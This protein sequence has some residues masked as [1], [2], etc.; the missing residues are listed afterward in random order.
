MSSNTDIISAGKSI[1]DGL[2][3]FVKL[4]MRWFCDIIYYAVAPLSG[5]QPVTGYLG[6][7]LVFVWGGALREG[8]IFCFPRVFC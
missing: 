7:A 3:I 6:L 4:E 2:T 8:F 5:L 1:F